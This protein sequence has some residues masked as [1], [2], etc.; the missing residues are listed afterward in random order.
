MNDLVPGARREEDDLGCAHG[1]AFG[2]CEGHAGFRT[3]ERVDRV[4]FDIDDCE[5][6]LEE[7]AGKPT[8]HAHPTQSGFTDV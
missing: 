7:E 6:G 4:M 5:Q 1:N 2:R 3:T 8:S